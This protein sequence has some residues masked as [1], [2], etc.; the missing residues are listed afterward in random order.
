MMK[1]SPG[2]R[3]PRLLDKDVEGEPARITLYLS[4]FTLYLSLFTFKT[5][6][7]MLKL[8]VHPHLHY[9]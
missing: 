6:V 7:L 9:I 5:I 8:K 4:L 3:I 2:V 1:E